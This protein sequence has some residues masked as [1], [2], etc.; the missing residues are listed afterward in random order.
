MSYHWNFSKLFRSKFSL[1]I[2]FYSYFLLYV[3]ETILAYASF[4][5]SI[6]D[7]SFNSFFAFLTEWFVHIG[8]IQL[9]QTFT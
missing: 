2:F 6:Y 9:V 3:S 8:S 1:G 4:R 5:A 7:P